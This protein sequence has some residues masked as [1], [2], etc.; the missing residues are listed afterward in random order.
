[1]RAAWLCLFLLTA[2][3]QRPLTVVPYHAEDGLVF[4]DVRVNGSSPR[5]F[6]L[7]TGAPHTV[8][9]SAAAVALKLGV[10]SRDRT[11]GAGRGTVGR[12]HLPPLDLELG[13]VRHRVVD[14]WAIDLGHVGIRPID[15]LV[16]ADLFERFVVRIDPDR[17]T[18]TLYGA[19]DSVP[20]LGIPIPLTLENDR[21]YVNMRLTLSNGISEVHRMRVDTGSSDAASDDLVRRSPVQSKVVQGVGLGQSYVG[22]SGVFETIQIGPYE[23]HHSWGASNEHPAVGMEILRRFTLTFDVPHRRLYLLPNRHLH[24]P[25]PA[26]QR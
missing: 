25:V 11:G 20:P 1:M 24:D 6:V 16:G 12:Q 13:G 18:L 4:L 21:L 23:I 15:G 22:V 10:L 9:D 8:V 17:R 7:D 3:P 2:A 26:P 5:T 14:P 19:Q